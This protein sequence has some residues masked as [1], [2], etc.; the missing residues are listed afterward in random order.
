MIDYL[1]KRLGKHNGYNNEL[2]WHCPA[3]IDNLGTESDKPKLA[4]NIEKWV[5]HCWRCEYR[6]RDIRTLLRYINNGRL[7]QE[8]LE[9]LSDDVPRKDENTS[10][11]DSVR[12]MLLEK[13][14]IT[15]PDFKA[16]PLPPEM[17]PLYTER[18]HIRR[19]IR[20]K[21]TI[22]FRYLERRG[23]PVSDIQRFKLG[24]CKDGDYAGYLII[25][26]FQGGTQVYW[27]SRYCGKNPMKTKN[28]PKADGFYTKEKVLLNFDSCM[29]KEVVAICEGPFDA[30]AHE[31]AVAVMGKTL[32]DYQLQ[33]LD[34]LAASGTKEFVISLD[35]EAI[36][37]TEK[38]YAQLISRFPTVSTLCL[39]DGDPHDNRSNLPTLMR[40]RGEMS[41]TARLRGRLL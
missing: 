8:E 17:L 6:F 39:T 35:A 38:I 15:S 29:G 36:R 31:N 27:T 18:E 25:P 41:V 12:D 30:M 32:S 10:L 24:Y 33:L 22:P 26:I 5:G 23:I 20:F 2:V 1:D 11:R 3:C 13:P 14:E 19:G 28:P 21:A 16:V 9:L 40:N 34:T 7:L 37:D 4:I